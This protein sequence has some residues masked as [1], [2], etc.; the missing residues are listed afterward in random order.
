MP[1][2]MLNNKNPEQHAA[3]NDRKRERAYIR[4]RERPI[5]KYKRAA[6]ED[7]SASKLP[8]TNKDAM[9]L[10][11]GGGAQLIVEGAG[12]I[13]GT[14]AEKPSETFSRTPDIEKTPKIILNTNS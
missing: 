5:H 7:E 1:A 2:V 10:I 3:G 12:C 8:T 11:A 13:Y 14:H 9:G 6:K 4:K